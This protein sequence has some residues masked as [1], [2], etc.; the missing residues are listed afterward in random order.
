[1]F[2]F[3]TQCLQHLRDIIL[4]QWGHYTFCSSKQ[5]FRCYKWGKNRQPHASNFR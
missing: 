3:K 2:L 5:S 4:L 1:M